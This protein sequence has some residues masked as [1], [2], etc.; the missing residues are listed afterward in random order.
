MKN[1][2]EEDQLMLKKTILKHR[3]IEGDIIERDKNETNHM[4]RSVRL[5][6]KIIYEINPDT[7]ENTRWPNNTIPYEFKKDYS[8][9]IL[10]LNKKQLKFYLYEKNLP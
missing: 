2:G 4:K 3:L 6:R 10:Q 8:K 7:Q 9:S 1:R 5:K